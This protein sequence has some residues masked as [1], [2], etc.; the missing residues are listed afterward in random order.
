M[1]SFKLSL[2]DLF[3]LLLVVAFA[4]GWFASFPPPPVNSPSLGN[5]AFAS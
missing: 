4:L 2:R 3:W 5:D 1:A